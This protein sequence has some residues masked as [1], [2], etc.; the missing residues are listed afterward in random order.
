VILVGRKASGDVR[1]AVCQPAGMGDREE[2]LQPVPQADC[3]TDVGQVK[4]PGMLT[5]SITG[6]QLMFIKVAL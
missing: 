1:Y 6:R 5:R 4:P 3:S 2:I